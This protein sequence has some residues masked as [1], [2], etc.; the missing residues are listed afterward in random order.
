[1][2]R[3]HHLERLL[4]R[5]DPYDVVIVGGGAT[6]TSSALDAASRGHSVLLIERQD[7]AKGTSSWSTK[8]IHGGVRYL[9]QGSISLVRKALRERAFLFRNTPHLVHPLDF[10]IPITRWW[11]G[12]FYWFGLKCYDALAGKLGL[13]P[14]G[15]WSTEQ[16]A[17]R[18][19]GVD[20]IG[21][22]G[23]VVYQ[24]GQFDD[25]RLAVT[26]TLT[27]A[28]R[29]ATILNYFNCEGLLKS[30]GRVIGVIATDLETGHVHEIRSHSVINATGVF[31]DELRRKDEEKAPPLLSISQGIHLVLPS[32][33]LPGDCALMVPETD[34]GRVFFALPWNG[35]VIAG[36]TDT[37]IDGFAI[38]PQAQ[39]QEI[40]FILEHAGRFLVRAPK[41]ADV[42]SV[43]AGL[44][45]LVR[46]G[47]ETNTSALSRDHFIQVAES[48]MITITGGKWTTCRQMAEDV[49]NQAERTAGLQRRNCLTRDL[50][51]IGS[52][53]KASEF[54]HLSPY[55]TEASNILQL[56]E[57]KPEL[58][59]CLHE[60]LPYQK[61]EVVW[62]VRHEM[63]RTVEDVLARRTR[64]LF[65]DAQASI[66]SADAVAN[67]MGRELGWSAAQ[68]KQSATSY[69]S[70]AENYLL[71]E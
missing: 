40:A 44:R 35:R 2:N 42:L 3:D 16:M 30:N 23:G 63:A 21:L 8:L 39:E 57:E 59:Q 18:I 27:A 56:I 10:V 55:G 65:L 29:G 69:R 22:R 34:D 28:D 25:A 4:S 66:E 32:S 33:F 11:H 13:A 26:L 62:H 58:A 36:T 17:E 1:M 7:F 31:V 60:R 14:S 54:A 47:T 50:P 15:W 49:V 41:R 38:E 71:S 64:A 6:G 12:P 51:L 24:D 5:S 68:C 61:A 46:K 70:V 52:T 45:P 67:L 20:R 37:P 53:T 43:F 9:R 19:P 48:G